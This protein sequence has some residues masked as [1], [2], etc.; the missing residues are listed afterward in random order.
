MCMKA[1]RNEIVEGDITKL[2]VDAIVNA[3]KQVDIPT[4][5]HL[6]RQANEKDGKLHKHGNNE[7]LPPLAPTWARCGPT[8]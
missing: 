3:A 1:G 6:S 7:A 8:C 4:L 2:K 5:Q